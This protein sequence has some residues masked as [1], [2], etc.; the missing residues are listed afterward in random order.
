M[1]EELGLRNIEKVDCID[2]LSH[3]IQM[4]RNVFPNCWFDEAGC[5]EGIAHLDGYKKMWSSTMQ[6]YTDQ[7]R[8][9]VHT[10]GADAFRQFAQG[11]E[12]AKPKAK[13]IE[14]I[15]WGQ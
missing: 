11:Y 9:D 7:P 5:K 8:K 6:R 1:L 14:K 2:D 10:E 15:G 13:R 3:G 4:T 12:D